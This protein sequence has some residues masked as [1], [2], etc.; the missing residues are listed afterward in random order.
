M[1]ELRHQMARGA[2][3]LM[4]ARLADRLIGM[5]S[6]ALLA[7]L[8]APSDFGLVA[9]ATAV[10]AGTELFRA[11]S[12]EVALIQNQEAAR[13][14]YDTTWTLNAI[15]GCGI[16]L[17]VALLAY[18]SAEFY[19][20]PRLLWVLAALAVRPA[21]TG[22]RNVGVV[23]FRKY[24]RFERELYLNLSTKVVGLLTTLPLAFYLR[25]YWAL[26]CGM[27][28]SALADLLLSYGMH[29]YRPRFSLKARG[30]LMH[31]SK[32]LFVNN[33][34][35]FLGQRGPEV[36][37]GKLAG[38]RALGIFSLAYEL[39]NLPTTELT[40]TINA[41]T[42]P[43]YAR[44]GRDVSALRAEFLQVMGF[45]FLLLL[46]AG[47]GMVLIA[48]LA[49]RTLLGEQWMDAVPVVQ[50]LAC[51]GM[52]SAVSS[53]SGYIYM[54]VG[55]PRFIT[56]LTAVQ[57][58]LL[59][60]GVVL[61][62]LHG[63]ALGAGWAYFAAMFVATTPLNYVIISRE[64]RLRFSDVFQRL[65][66]PVLGTAGMVACV[67]GIRG[68]L[69]ARGFGGDVLALLVLSAAGAAVY[70]AVV[71]VL[72]AFA[73]RPPGAESSSLELLRTRLSQPV[74]RG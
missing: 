35:F 29:P 12:F 21:L 22:A 49:V 67:E 10:I 68:Y 23:D 30:D 46:P 14:E 1:S 69:P 20:D 64:L 48:D 13:A 28:A 40:A 63:G 24:Y 27:L 33:L 53:N 3:W 31:F 60:P 55:K 57:L 59:L 32:W 15:L 17:V 4:L 72:W 65:W 34:G 5:V 8:L 54:A 66:R 7:R 58:T 41:A 37:V 47:V 73:D 2:G 36:L 44:H 70:A 62:S 38:T 18:P 39:A 56:L 26:V 6:I 45:V 51:A 42:F 9:I 19:G 50:I 61:G 74:V 11:F 43:G 52:L 25:S 16:A 71:M